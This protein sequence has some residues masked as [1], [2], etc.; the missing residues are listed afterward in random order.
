MLFRSS[1][2]ANGVSVGYDASGSAGSLVAPLARYALDRL[3][4]R[5]SR[6][7]RMK[8]T[9]DTPIVTPQ[10]IINDGADTDWTPLR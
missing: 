6:S 3:S 1:A 7:V 8:R 2:A 4:W 9:K 10:T 5:R